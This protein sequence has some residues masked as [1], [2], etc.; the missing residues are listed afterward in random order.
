MYMIIDKNVFSFRILINK[1][2]KM[3]FFVHLTGYCIRVNRGVL[4]GNVDGVREVLPVQTVLFRG[5]VLDGRHG[6]GTVHGHRSLL[7]HQSICGNE[8]NTRKIVKTPIYYYII[9]T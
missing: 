9:I 3:V 1:S 4:T 5:I 7:S 2:L 8:K 6:D